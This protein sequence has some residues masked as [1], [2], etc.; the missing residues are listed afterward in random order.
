[1]HAG[2]TITETRTSSVMCK[3]KRG[4]YKK[5]STFLVFIKMARSQSESLSFHRLWCCRCGGQSA[6]VHKEGM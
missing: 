3:Y 2:V 4:Y 1:M 5:L 6:Q